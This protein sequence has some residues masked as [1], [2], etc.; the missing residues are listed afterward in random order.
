[1]TGFA[2]PDILKE[3]HTSYMSGDIDG[4]TDIFYRYCPLIR[5]ENQPGIGLAIRKNIYQRRGAIKTA[6]ARQ[7][8]V[9]LDKETL[10]DLT[11]LLTRLKLD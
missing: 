8:Y 1:M 4:A 3:I 2:F 11:D 7:P 6:Y 5:F 9:P 10:T